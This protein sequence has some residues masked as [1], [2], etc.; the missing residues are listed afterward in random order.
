MLFRSF[1]NLT[2]R[3]LTAVKLK[4]DDELAF[5]TLAK[6]DEELAIATS[7]GRLIRFA[8]DDDNLPVMGRTAQGPQALRLRKQEQ[9]VGCVRIQDEND[10]VL[11]VSAA[12]FAKRLP[13]GGIH[14]GARG[15]IG[16][17]AFLFKQKTD[18]LVAVVPC[19]P[20]RAITVVT[21]ES[22]SAQIPVG[23]V[24]RQ[25]RDTLTGYRLHKL[26]KGER[27]ATVTLTTLVDNE[28][29]GSSA[30]DDSEE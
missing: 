27:I 26:A 17:Q 19:P 16:T 13:V 9:I 15:G 28:S 25:G 6:A 3:G 21:T 23:D 29:S 20:Q 7:G 8:I 14:L 18:N 1:Q 4:K 22:R 24:P 11:L 10:C 2:G 30:E 12:G 5:V